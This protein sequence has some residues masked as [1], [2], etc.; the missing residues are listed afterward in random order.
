ML[1]LG[2]KKATSE[3]GC[4]KGGRQEIMC[5]CRNCEI[6]H[7]SETEKRRQKVM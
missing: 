1:N 4:K 3:G 6:L 5:C 2:P 7:E